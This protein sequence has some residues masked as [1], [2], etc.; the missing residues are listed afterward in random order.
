[1][2]VSF[3]GAFPTSAFDKPK[4]TTLTAKPAET[5]SAEQKF[6]DYAKMT[7]AERMHGP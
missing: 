1:M 5:K 4:P 7:P 2:T 6:L 3:S